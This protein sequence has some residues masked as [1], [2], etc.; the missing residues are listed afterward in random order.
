VTR[1]PCLARALGLP[2]VYDAVYP[3]EAEV[4]EA[5]FWTFDVRLHRAAAGTLPRVRLVGAAG[6]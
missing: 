1:A 6:A 4:E 2:G 5:E 3:A